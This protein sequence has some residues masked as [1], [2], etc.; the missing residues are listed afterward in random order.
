MTGF[1]LSEAS[2][3]PR[4]VVT[5]IGAVCRTGRTAGD[6]WK[7][8]TSPREPADSADGVADFSGRIDD[9]CELPSATRKAIQKSLKLMNRETQ[10]GVAAGQQALADSRIIGQLD[11]DRI[12]ICFGAENFPVMPEDFQAGVEA[13]SDAAGFHSDRWGQTGIPEVAPLWLL[14]CLPNMPACHLAILNDLRGPGNTVTQRDVAGNMAIAEACRILKDGDADAMVVGATGTTIPISRTSRSASKKKN[15]DCD[16]Y[17]NVDH[18]EHHDESNDVCRPF[19]RRRQRSVPGEGAGVI[20]L[21]ELQS[22]LQRGATIYGEILSASSSSGHGRD[23]AAACRT[24]LINAMRQALHRASLSPDG[25]G[26]I[27]AHG[28]GTVASDIAEAEAI[29]QVFGDSADRIPVVAAKSQLSNAGAGSGILELISSLLALRH[30]HLFPVVNF[31]EHDPRCPIR[32]ARNCSDEAG[33]SFLNLNV[34]GRGMASC[35]AAG[36]YRG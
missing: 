25:V 27:H 35:V 14:K 30:G 18:T 21:E 8:L 3:R 24:G 1:G 12:G 16:P 17:S 32:P 26:H 2:T 31:S 20:V 28:L 10:I 22:A 15:A 4:I 5:G 7:S 11:P 29:R 19:D 34:F 33:S 23:R 6:L 36:I 13:C 9:F